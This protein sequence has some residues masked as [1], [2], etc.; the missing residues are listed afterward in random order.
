MDVDLNFTSGDVKEGFNNQLTFDV[1][2][3]SNGRYGSVSGTNLWDFTVYGSSSAD[4]SGPE[5]FAQAVAQGD[6][7]HRSLVAGVDTDFNNLQVLWDL[8]SAETCSD[9][10]YICI[11]ISKNDAANPDFLLEPSSVLAGCFLSNCRG[12]TQSSLFLISLKMLKV[13]FVETFKWSTFLI[14][15]SI[16][17]FAN[18]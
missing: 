12:E 4:G 14:M 7:V 5:V 18:H 3:S 17:T 1:T 16:G 6:Q 9:V 11:N 10:E 8:T 15:L 13:C 2:L